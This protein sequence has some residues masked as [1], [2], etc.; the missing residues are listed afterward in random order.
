MLLR[1]KC[2]FCWII[3]KNVNTWMVIFIPLPGPQNSTTKEH[4]H[5]GEAA[6]LLL[7]LYHWGHHVTGLD[8]GQRTLGHVYY[9]GQ[10]GLSQWFFCIY[11]FLGMVILNSPGVKTSHFHFSLWSKGWFCL[12]FFKEVCACFCF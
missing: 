11:F 4:G 5:P 7:L 1:E 9:R 12:K 8:P 3:K 2:N 6:V 10:V